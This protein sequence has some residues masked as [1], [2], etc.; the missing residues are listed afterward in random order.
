MGTAW[1]IDTDKDTLDIGAPTVPLQCG[2]FKMAALRERRYSGRCVGTDF[3]PYL[4][5][6]LCRLHDRQSYLL[7]ALP[8][9]FGGGAGRIFSGAGR[10]V[11]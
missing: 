7:R 6:R 1:V 8:K 10:A 4:Q 3:S 2:V 9:Y 5:S 11:A